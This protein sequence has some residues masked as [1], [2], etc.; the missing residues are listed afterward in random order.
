[1]RD[2]RQHCNSEDVKRDV[3]G[4]L[5]RNQAT[6]SALTSEANHDGLSKNWHRSSA[7]YP[8]SFPLMAQLKP[9]FAMTEDVLCKSLCHFLEKI[10][11][12]FCLYFEVGE[13]VFQEKCDYNREKQSLKRETKQKLREN[14]VT[15][16]K[17]EKKNEKAK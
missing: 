2:Y 1:M 4:L 8:A 16:A 9:G 6:L 17:Q 13:R 5:A 3:E 10:L 15:K 12:R 11:Q 7:N 14:K